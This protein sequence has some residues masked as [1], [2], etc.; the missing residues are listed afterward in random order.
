MAPFLEM[1]NIVKH[2]PGV[3]AN[4]HVNFS[5]EPGEIHALLGENGAGKSTLMQILYGLYEPDA[6][7]ILVEGRPVQIRNPRD[8]IA[9]G[10]G[11]I[12]QDFMLI[13]PFTVVENIIL[14]LEDDHG[15]LLDLQ[16][17]KL[18]I[19]ELSE[20]H[21]LS[22]DPTARIENLPVGVQQRVE[23]LKLLYRNAKLLILD[24]PT[25][26]L[27]PQEANSLFDVVRSLKAKG[28]SVVFITHKLHE[29]INVADRVTVL[30]DGKVI[31]TVKT[32]ETNPRELARMMV[33]R[34]VVFR[35]SKK[36]CQPGKTALK[37]QDLCAC[38]NTLVPKVRGVSFELREGEILGLAGVDGNGQSELAEAMMNLRPVSGGKIILDEKEITHLSTAK[39]RAA[40]IAYIPADRRQVGTVGTL[41]ISYNTIL[42]EEN[43]YSTGRV[44]LNEGRIRAHARELVQH[45][46]VKTPGIDFLA[47]KLSGG[48]LQKVVLGREIMRN[49]RVL[50]IEQPTRGLDV[51]AIE[52]IQEQ[53]IAERDQGAAIFLISADLEEILTLSDRIA[54]IYQGQMMG[55]IAACDAE[56]AN[57]GLMMAGTPAEQLKC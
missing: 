12:H 30:R 40:G 23:I 14:G 11:M 21:G 8:A 31:A 4:D 6:G 56:M 32:S 10:I 38:D 5:V 50:I 42:G 1:R 47:G 16:A 55:T 2:F 53:I 9:Q 13:P 19:S 25:A 46:N 33:G 39:H 7:E 37:V 43:Q 24:E 26:V 15:Q 41:S 17:A 44:F 35:I 54:V 45:Y 18:R 3:V 20:R 48:N 34:E 49:P 28:H 51:G 27:T 57:I 52:Y 36:P 22:V 29:V